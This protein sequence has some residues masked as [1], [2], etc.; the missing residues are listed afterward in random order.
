MLPDSY[1]VSLLLPDAAEHL[2]YKITINSKKVQAFP[3][4]KARKTGRPA[5]GPSHPLVHFQYCYCTQA[6]SAPIRKS[7]IFVLVAI[8]P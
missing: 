6:P 1:L 2:I 4:Q 3:L 8:Y 7:P 5:R